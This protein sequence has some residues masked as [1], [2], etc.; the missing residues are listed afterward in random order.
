[1]GFRSKAHNFVVTSCCLKHL[2]RPGI[3][4]LAVGPPVG[5]LAV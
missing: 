1:M 4:C 3:A 2:R 5:K